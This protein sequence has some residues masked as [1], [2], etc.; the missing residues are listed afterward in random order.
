M[1]PCINKHQLHWHSDLCIL[2]VL[3][4]TLRDNYHDTCKAQ[5]QEHGRLAWT[6]LA[7]AQNYA[8]VRMKD[9]SSSAPKLAC[10][11]IIGNFQHPSTVCLCLR[12]IAL[13]SFT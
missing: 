9:A 7:S 1:T 6:R 3:G 12:A 8:E 4:L 2:G 5:R 13:P 10:L 11:V